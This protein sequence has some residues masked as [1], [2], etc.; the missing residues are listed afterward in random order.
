MHARLVTITGSDVNAAVKFLDEKVGPAAAQQRG[1]RQLAASG[2]R[3]RGVLSVVSVWDRK[4]DLEAS[5]SA[6]AKLREEGLASFGGQA[7]VKV[8]EQTV[9][10]TGATPPA[11]GCVLQLVHFK[12]DPSKIDGNIGAFKNDV[13]PRLKTLAGFRAVRHMVDRA[14]GEGRTGI[15]FS[16]RPSMEAGQQTRSQLMTAARERGVQFG[17]EDVLEVLYAR[18]GTS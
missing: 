18:M 10:E 7:T 15:V 1:F 11:P 2:D 12:M 14:T 17:D 5:D 8:F 16:D 6:I 9:M 13:V 4:E 3:S